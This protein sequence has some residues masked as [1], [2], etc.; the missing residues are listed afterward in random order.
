M[1]AA[2]CGVASCASAAALPRIT[3]AQ[4]AT[5]RN[6]VAVLAMDFMMLACDEWTRS[7][8]RRMR[9]AVD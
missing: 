2:G 9:C 1:R 6:A 3:T 5:T 7:E 4:A 8:A